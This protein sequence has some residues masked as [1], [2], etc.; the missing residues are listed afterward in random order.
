[1]DERLLDRPFLALLGID[2]LDVADAKC[3]GVISWLEMGERN[4]R[5]HVHFRQFRLLEK[6]ALM[7]FLL[8]IHHGVMKR[9]VE[10][11]CPDLVIK[12]LAAV[13]FV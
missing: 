9:W 1:M 5:L 7:M 11:G 4:L 8:H 12:E 6:G 13:E 3:Y 10:H 2:P